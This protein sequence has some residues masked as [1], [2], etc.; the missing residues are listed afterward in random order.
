M[1]K[2][3]LQ[4]LKATL[5]LHIRQIMHLSMATRA[6]LGRWLY[7]DLIAATYNACRQNARQAAL[8]LGLPTST[9]RRRM[10]KIENQHSNAT[11]QRIDGW[12]SIMASLTPIVEG[13]ISFGDDTFRQL[14][15]ILLSCIVAIVP[16]N[17]T[18]ASALLGVSEPT[19]Y[20]WKKELI[21]WQGGNTETCPV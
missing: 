19:F 6:P 11:T 16:D 12:Q 14:K 4:E 3:Y 21:E 9:L 7:D 2:I 10:N 1:I 5:S 13:V 8:R 20:K 18:I 15:L 17:A